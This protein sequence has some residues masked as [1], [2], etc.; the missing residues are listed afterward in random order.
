MPTCR[1]VLPMVLVG[2]LAR[3]SAAAAR[4]SGEQRNTDAAAR[5]R[6]PLRACF[7]MVYI[8]N[9]TYPMNYHENYFSF[10]GWEIQ[11]IR[12]FVITSYEIIKL[13]ILAAYKSQI[14][15]AIDTL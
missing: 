8:N 14:G 10:N 12:A 15:N 9:C 7:N 3:L 2:I 11:M 6:Q 4:N 5:T 13:H 1:P